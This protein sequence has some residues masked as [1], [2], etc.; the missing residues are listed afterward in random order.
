MGLLGRGAPMPFVGNVSF[1]GSATPDSTHVLVAI[2]LANA[3]LTFAREDDRFRAGYTVTIT[4]R[5]GAVA[6]RNIEAHEEV[7]VATFRE[8]SRGDESILY[9]E[10]MTVPPGRYD[11]TVR[12]RDDGSARVSEDAAS[13]NVPPLGAGALSSP[14]AF[15]RA[16]IR[17][18]TA[19]L[20]QIIANPTASVT[21]GRDTNVTFFVESYG[22]GA[23]SR[24]IQYAV[25]SDQGRPIY[26]DSA[27]LA[28]RGELYSG[29]VDVPIAK[30]GIGAMTLNVWSADRA[31]TVRTPFFVGFGPDLPLA[32]YD[33]MV[34]YLR[35][36]ASGADLQ[37]LRN[38]PPE[39]RPAAWA[40]FVRQHEDPNG[41]MEPMRDYFLRMVDANTRF[42]EEASP[43]WMTDRGRVLLGL[44]RPDQVYEQMSRALVQA[45]R[46]QV[47]EYR[48]LNIA[49][50]FYDQNGFGRWK[51]TPSSDAEFM[52]AWR[53]RV[54]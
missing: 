45:G 8:T 30:V 25:R 47:W 44:G 48:N 4:L 6:V 27:T 35:W 52:S 28:R 24:A 53:R 50:T 37:E 15:A 54:Q 19:S 21:F 2:S 10:L 3:S 18:S 40:E 1:F 23:A 41:S 32:S 31:D 14:V 13:L 46:Q 49:L 29:T 42:K 26:R 11:F 12:V 36:F 20:P 33:E 38:A 34:N 17:S 16:T 51:L 22:P 7:L 9:E 5:S 43:G 39:A